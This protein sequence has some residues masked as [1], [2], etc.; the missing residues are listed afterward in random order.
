MG[1]EEGG[2]RVRA[3]DWDEDWGRG[4][5]YDQQSAKRRG[6]EEDIG[7]ADVC[8]WGTHD[9]DWGYLYLCGNTY[10]MLK[11]SIDKQCIHCSVVMS[12]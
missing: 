9:V 5:C 3:C 8:G 4:G 7:Q 1:V 10:I 11:I 6:V 12:V 2:W